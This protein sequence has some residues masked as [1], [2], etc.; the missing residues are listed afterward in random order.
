MNSEML[1]Y[2]FEFFPGNFPK[3]TIGTE[4]TAVSSGKKRKLEDGDTYTLTVSSLE[5]FV[6]FVLV[7]C[8]FVLFAQSINFCNY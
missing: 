4:I 5:S 6:I 7:N 2:L 1:M 3:L 8:S